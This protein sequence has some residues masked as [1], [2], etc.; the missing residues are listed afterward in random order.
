MNDANSWVANDREV[1]L[2]PAW[3]CKIF[4][5]PHHSLR[6]VYFLFGLRGRLDLEWRRAGLQRLWR[7]LL[8]RGAAYRRVD[9]MSDANGLMRQ[10]S[11]PESATLCPPVLLWVGATMEWATS[12]SHGPVFGNGRNGGLLVEMAHATPFRRTHRRGLHVWI[13]Q[14]PSNLTANVGRGKRI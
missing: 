3:V 13:S 6:G 1:K 10:N 5:E 8:N 11:W 9:P 12:W 14:A 4:E 7:V 2:G